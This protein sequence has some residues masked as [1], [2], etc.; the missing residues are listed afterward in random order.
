MGPGLI[1]SERVSSIEVGRALLVRAAVG[2]AWGVGDVL[3]LETESLPRST[4]FPRSWGF[5][6]L[7]TSKLLPRS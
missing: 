3:P 1:E 6:S 2:R 4:L 5:E 7:L